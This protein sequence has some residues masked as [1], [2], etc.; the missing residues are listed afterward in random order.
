VNRPWNHGPH[1]SRKRGGVALVI[2]L[3]FVVILC[4]LVVAYFSRTSTD[5]QLAGASF[6]Q[7][8]ADTLA[9]GALDIIVADFKQEIAD[10]STSSIVGGVT[11]Y[12]PTLAANVVPQ[13]SG[14]QITTPNLI[15]RSVSPDSI[16]FPGIGSRASAVNST[17]D[18]SANGRF[19]SLARW[20]S[21]YLLPKSD[22]TSDGSDPVPSFVAPDWILVSRNGPSVQGNLGSGVTALN[23][24]SV[25][26]VNYVIGRYAFA[27]YDEG[28]LLDINVAGFPSPSPAPATTS[29][30]KGTVAFADLTALP[31]TSSGFVT[32]TAINRMVAWRNYA[33]VQPTGTFP[34]FTFSATS[35]ST[36][37]TYFLDMTRNFGTVGTTVWSGRTDQAFI[38]RAQLIQLRADIG[39]SVNMLQYL[40]T[41]SR[42]NNKPTWGTAPLTSRFALSKLAQVVPNPGN[43]AAV[44]GD[45]GLVWNSD[46][47]EYWSSSGTAEQSTI[48]TITG[49]SADFFQLLSYGRSNP[50]IAETLALGASLIDQ[51]DADNTT[52]VI[53]YAGG[54]PPSR[55]Y[56]MESLAIPTPSPAPSP[57]PGV[58]I[59]NRPFRNVGEFGYAYKTTTTTLD[60]KSNNADAPLLDLFTFNTA[61]PRSGI[62]NLNTR[63][64]SVLAAIIKGTF[65]TEASGSGITNAQATSAATSV[66]S[67]TTALPAIGRQDVAR[68]GSAPT[69][70]PFTSNEESRESTA[71]ALAEVGQTRTW[72]LLIDIIAQSGRYPPNA[73]SGPNVA[74]PLANFVV[75]GER[76]YWL[77]I[78]IDRITGEVIDQQLEAVFE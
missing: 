64:N 68:L 15:R 7:M 46:H 53:E 42:E 17:T 59:L 24:R 45:F 19:I 11:T 1:L 74:N 77:H 37:A 50:P 47:W 31:T 62:V 39:A 76:R 9:R 54:P 13:R 5:R 16:S 57:P 10:G 40:G 3:G 6:N 20:N 56:G 30:R 66:V 72:G 38:S 26:N 73:A 4:L 34:N 60:F 18:V 8:D 61:T 21:H 55:A 43:A 49:A 2:V 67:T 23:N 25:T 33:T 65:P 58:V 14:T 63:N 51:Y 12:T 28:G 27:V 75:E 36:F 48:P 35:S 32:N 44:K 69:T 52:T 78:A 71:R 41:F 70:T 22:L 29:G